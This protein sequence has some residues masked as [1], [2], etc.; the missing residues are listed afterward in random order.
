M[1]AKEVVSSLCIDSLTRLWR[2]TGLLVSGVNPNC[3]F[4]L[5]P[6]GLALEAVNGFMEA[7]FRT[8][9]LKRGC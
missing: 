2:S 7:D 3:K 6:R 1:L 9:K 5:W 4:I 8:S